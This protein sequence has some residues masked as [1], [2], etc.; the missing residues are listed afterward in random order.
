V[1]QGETL[2]GRL[3]SSLMSQAQATTANL[4]LPH[5][6]IDGEHE[7]LILKLKE[8][9]EYRELLFFLVWREL[10]VKYQQTAIGVAWAVLQPVMTVLI[11]TLV[12]G[13][14]AKMPSDGVPYIVFSLAGLVPWKFFEV[15]LVQVSNSLVT[16][17][18]LLSKVYFPRLV[19]PCSAVLS[20]VVDLLV[21]FVLL[22]IVMLFHGL[23][24]SVR[25]LFLPLFL[26]LTLIV[27]LG[28]GLWLAAFNVRFRDVKY[29]VPFLVQFWM[30]GTPL[31]YP[32]SKI[33]EK[34]QMLYGLNPM[35][36]V[37]EGFRWCVLGTGKGPGDMFAVSVAAA[38]VIFVGGLLYFA[39]TEKRFAD[40]V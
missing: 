33:P 40:L 38:L 23:V 8:L 9:W 6:V 28:V 2:T 36:G 4:H 26:L 12:F 30:F 14:L 3:S 5:L 20:G 24:P 35:V 27:A 25:S 34:W 39:R 10:K 15:G 29:L 13:R 19:I 32:A 21:T 17:S 16:S 7:S 31:L 11:Y 22:I 18:G 1:P 37:L